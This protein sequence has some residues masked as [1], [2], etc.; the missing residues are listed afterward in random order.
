VVVGVEA[1]AHADQREVLAVHVGIDDRAQ[2]ATSRRFDARADPL[3]LFEPGELCDLELSLADL[4][5][6]HGLH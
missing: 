3:G 5:Y 6:A 1:V 4:V 2:L